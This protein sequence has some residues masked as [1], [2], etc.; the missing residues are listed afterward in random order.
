MPQVEIKRLSGYLNSDDSN[1]TIGQ[2]HH[3]M[4]MDVL[5]RGG[6][7][8]MTAIGMPG[9]ILI[10]AELP[11]G[12]NECIGRIY[13]E[14]R[15][16]IYYFIWNSTGK[17]S[18]YRCILSGN[19]ITAVVISG[20][21]SDSDLL[22][23]DRNYPIS[24]ISILYGDENSGDILF[25][26]DSDG[27][28]CLINVDKAIAGTY[29]T[30]KKSYLEV[31][32]APANQPPRVVYE[33]DASIIVNN[34]R[35]RLFLF[36]TR[37]VYVDKLKSVWSTISQMPLP[38]NY[39]DSDIDKDPTKNCKIAIAIPTG[40]NDV[41]EV[42][43]AAMILPLDKVSAT[44]NGGWFTIKVLN[45]EKD[46]I[47]SNDLYVFR[48]FND[49]SYTP[50]DAVETSQLQDLVPL[51]ANAVAL[52]NGNIP[53]YGGIT[54]G[55]NKTSVNGSVECGRTEENTTQ[56]P[57]IFVV[58]Q[59]GNS[60][61]GTGNIHAV[62]LGKP[63]VGDKFSIVTSNENIEFTCTVS[64]TANVVNGLKAA[65]LLAGFTIISFDSENLIIVKNGESLLLVTGITSLIPISN[66]FVYDRNSR[67]N[68]GIIYFDNNNRNIGTQTYNGLSISTMDYSEN[69][70]TP[71][72]PI[73]AVEIT[74]RP[75]IYARYYQIVRS[76]NLSKLWKLEWVSERTLKDKEYA[77]IS[78]ENLNRFIK[79][80]P[81]SK[82]LA[83]DYS[84][85]DRIRFI[86]RLSSGGTIYTDKD[87]SIQSVVFS[88]EINGKVTEGQ[89]IKI[90]LPT[91]SITFDFGSQ[92]FYN[93]FIEIYTPQKSTAD[94]ID[95]YY[96]ISE[97]YGIGNA[98]TVNA[99]HQGQT[100][101]QSAD[102]LTNAVIRLSQ[103]D[104]YYRKR[105]INT[106]GNLNY[107]ITAGER[108]AGRH[109]VG[110]DFVDRDFTDANITTGNSPLLNL[111]GW[112]PA[113]DTRALI[114]MGAGAETTTFKAKG[115]I[116]IDALYA[117]AFYWYFEDNL[118]N[119]TYINNLRAIKQGEETYE[120]DCAFTLSAGQHISFI[121]FSVL[122][123]TNSKWYRETELKI[124]I[125]K[126]YTVNV[127][128]PNFSDYFQSVVNSNGRPS[129]VDIDAAQLKKGNLLR[130]GLNYLPNSNI[131]QT[132]RFREIN[133][134][135]V[136]LGKG[137]I[138]LLEVNEMQLRIYQQ[139]GVGVKGIYGKFI[140][141][142]N[143][144]N[145]L[146][147]TDDI[148]SKNNID[149]YAKLHG[150]GNHPLSF[151]RSKVASY[152]IDHRTG[153]QI[154]IDGE[155][156][157]S[158]S[159]QNKGA[160]YIKSIILPYNFNITSTSGVK[161]R[162]IQFFDEYENQ[163]GCVLTGGMLAD[164]KIDP[165]LFYF[166]EG[167]NAY[168]TFS[169]LEPE[170]II[171]AAGKVYSWKNGSMYIHDNWDQN[172]VDRGYYGVPFYPS[173]TLVF[174]DKEAVRKKYLALGYQS[175]SSKLWTSNN[176]GD[177]NTNTIN[178]QTGLR[179][180]SQLLTQDFEA[181]ETMKTASFLYD[182][183][184][185]N[186]Q[187]EGLLNGDFLGGNWL[188]IKLTSL[189]SSSNF[190]Y[191]PYITWVQSNRNF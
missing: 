20:T 59:S 43:V 176:F 5:W 17:H 187:S 118:G 131:N 69:V 72:I 90:K 132:N 24:A 171:A 109:T 128:D 15:N 127:I 188:E 63:I 14:K 12:S 35:R 144:G 114:K 160:Y 19:I 65:A 82:H 111:S 57:Y 156:I 40:E 143:G 173:V 83:Y 113:S 67:Y 159:Q 164:N 104:F 66:S 18:I 64:T 105:D 96:E 121:G 103:G 106:G 68:I 175:E 139:I 162:I 56:P 88:P 52:L 117:D 112:T 107:V 152:F 186:S 25:F 91:T 78:I 123:V 34:L 86:K 41:L 138:M 189:I 76:S 37:Y 172:N 46:N 26:N 42:E 174:N 178:P 179:Q 116:T 145:I 30:I 29:G 137:D 184:S 84:D 49:Q 165:H 129:I 31:I 16:F 6:Q 62:I 170:M 99:F 44:E 142:G 120:I 73:I 53:V 36:R 135:E 163:C 108:G 166:H 7:N 45:K 97:R 161:A 39:Q 181:E 8:G 71:T 55:Y 28:P 54:E 190:L 22:N 48:F 101:N 126:R 79:D 119:K 146:T 100:Q 141:D 38:I 149:Y 98:G 89:F 33:D 169:V 11:N 183:N 60:G 58:N 177:I 9:T 136:D 61:F 150:I 133:F 21:N 80:N 180:I 74:S 92:N 130:W 70:G 4:A 147:T 32:K 167:R 155:G 122:D 10:N 110:V 94:G 115:K 47:A 182:V 95:K 154:R 102:L 27:K 51:K 75:P 81:S 3:K 125:E 87:F 185:R 134:D 93:Y 191:L 157:N 158:I 50:C 151:T 13:C 168:S 1:E 2:T 153:E 148:L 124:T 85:G 140:Q 23:F 77:Y